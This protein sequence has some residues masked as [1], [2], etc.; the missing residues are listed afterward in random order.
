MANN[1]LCEFWVQTIDA[2][3]KNSRFV[4]VL[5]CV[6]RGETLSRAMSNCE[7]LPADSS[8]LLEAMRIDKAPFQRWSYWASLESLPR[9][10]LENPL[11]VLYLWPGRLGKPLDILFPTWTKDYL[12]R[13]PGSLEDAIRGGGGR[14]GGNLHDTPASYRLH[15]PPR[16]CRDFLFAF[17]CF[18]AEAHSSCRGSML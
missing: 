4:A 10:C 12:R 13:R 17:C 11:G 16:G 18:L 3:P 15:P 14:E 1:D 2:A 8:T 5:R 9:R 6:G 7:A